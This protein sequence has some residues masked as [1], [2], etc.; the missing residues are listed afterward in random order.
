M[1]TSTAEGAVHV[2]DREDDLDEATEAPGRRQTAAWAAHDDVSC[3]AIAFGA[4]GVRTVRRHRRRGRLRARLAREALAALGA[5]PAV[6]TGAAAAAAA[7]A[8]GGRRAGD[9]SPICARARARR[10]SWT[11][12]PPSTAFGWPPPAPTASCASTRQETRWRCSGGSSRTKPRRSSRRGG[13]GDGVAAATAADA[14]RPRAPATSAHRGSLPAALAVALVWHADALGDGAKCDAPGLDVRRGACVGASRRFCLRR[15]RARRRP[16][17][18]LG[19]QR[20]RVARRRGGDRRGGARL[21]GGGVP[22]GALE[23]RIERRIRLGTKPRVSERLAFQKKRVGV[24]DAFGD[25]RAAM[26]VSVA[27]R[28]GL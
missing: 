23:R 1:V 12:R 27:P 4:G 21:G 26:R 6:A 15:A 7:A 24:V 18:R 8:R 13:F 28:A 17:S 9:S 11:S 16:G 10:R 22:R 2:W 19:A 20:R 5:E 25:Q 14:A 3:E